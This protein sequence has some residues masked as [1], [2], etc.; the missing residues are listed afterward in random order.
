MLL[1]LKGAIDGVIKPMDLDQ[2]RFLEVFGYEY[3]EPAVMAKEA[4]RRK[5]TLRRIR[6][7]AAK[8]ENGAWTGWTYN[9]PGT[10]QTKILH[11]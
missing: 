6:A 7:A 8:R 3:Q 4:E 2:E 5:R 9:R 11:I 1:Y 10:R